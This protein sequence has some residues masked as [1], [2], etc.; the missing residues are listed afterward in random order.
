M[1]GIFLMIL[2][3]TAAA[4]GEWHSEGYTNNGQSVAVPVQPAIT[5]T[6][7]DS[8]AAEVWQPRTTTNADGKVITNAIQGRIT[9]ASVTPVGSGIVD[10]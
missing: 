3:A 10:L 1:K 7:A 5:T 4:G 6:A 9:T 2:S 8:D